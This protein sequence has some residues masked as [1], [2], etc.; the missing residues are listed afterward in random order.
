M[1]VIG[2]DH[3]IGSVIEYFYPEPDEKIIDENTKK[4]L[5]FIGLPDGSHSVLSDYSFFIVPDANGK[6]YYGVS[7]F[8]QIRSS[9]LTE[10]DDK[11][12]RS[13]V[14]KSVWALSRIPIFATLMIKL[15]PTTHAYFKQKNFKDT[16]ILEEF[17]GS[18]NKPGASTIKY[19]DLFTGF[20]LKRIVIYLKQNILTLLKLLLLEGKIVVYS[21]KASKV[22]TFVLSLFSLLPGASHFNYDNGK[23][24]QN[25]ISHY[26]AYGLPLK[27]FNNRWIFLPLSTLNDLDL[28]SEWKGLLIGCTNKLFMQYPTIKLDCIINLD[29]NEFDF[30]QTELCKLAKSHTSMEKHFINSL[31]KQLK[32]IATDLTP[33]QMYFWDSTD[34]DNMPDIESLDHADLWAK[35]GINSYIKQLLWRLSFAEICAREQETPSSSKPKEIKC[36]KFA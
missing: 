27:L 36:K 5:S 35:N 10:K 22:W 6:L 14:Q 25:V 15:L 30:K 9:E 26:G 33:E 23:E 31:I 8:R 16:K 12:S 13:F 11:I 28:L 20:D 4:A 21:Q 19:S 24:I 7:W 17:Y 1:F 18:V 29:D 34:Q 2:F 32:E 3:K